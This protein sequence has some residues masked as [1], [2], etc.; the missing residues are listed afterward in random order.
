MKKIIS[1]WIKR[2]HSLKTYRK[3]EITHEGLTKLIQLKPRTQEVFIILLEHIKYNV[4]Y[5]ELFMDLNYQDFRFACPSNFSKYKR[6]LIKSELV[7]TY[8]N[9]YFVNPYYVDYLSRRQKIIYTE[10]SN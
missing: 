4:D 6:E 9:K 5:D 3:Y 1:H 8:D 10:D 2:L 7:L